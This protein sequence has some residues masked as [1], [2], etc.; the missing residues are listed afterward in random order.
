M[1][2]RKCRYHMLQHAEELAT[3]ANRQLTQAERNNVL[4]YEDCLLEWMSMWLYVSVRYAMHA[5]CWHRERIFKFS[6]LYV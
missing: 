6:M 1:L 5:Y 4:N 3:A 2:L